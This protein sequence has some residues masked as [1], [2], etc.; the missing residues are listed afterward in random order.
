MIVVLFVVVA[1]VIVVPALYRHSSSHSAVDAILL[2]LQAYTLRTALTLLSVTGRFQGRKGVGTSWDAG[3]LTYNG[4]NSYHLSH[5]LV[6]RPLRPRR[7]HGHFFVLRVR[8]LPSLR[9]RDLCFDGLL[10]PSSDKTIS[11]PPLR[12]WQLASRE[13]YVHIGGDLGLI[14]CFTVLAIM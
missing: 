9:A 7:L 14:N 12:L 8:R 10:W 1:F 6:R 13:H 5:V 2:S 4:P 3:P 11:V